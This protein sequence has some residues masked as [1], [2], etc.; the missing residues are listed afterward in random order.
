MTA[1][2]YSFLSALEMSM[3]FLMPASSLV[4]WQKRK[5]WRA[6]AAGVDEF[7]GRG[8]LGGLGLG[9][10]AREVQREQ[11]GDRDDKAVFSW[12]SSCSPGDSVQRAVAWANEWRDRGA[13]G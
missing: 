4:V 1:S 6:S 7:L 8:G 13:T 5:D 11:H 2:V 12:G 3:L 10:R 9:G